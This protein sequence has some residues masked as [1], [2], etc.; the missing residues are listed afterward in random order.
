MARIIKCICHGT[1]FARLRKI[2]ES[3]K[4]FSIEKLQRR[5]TFAENCRRCVPY[6]KLMLETGQTEFDL[7]DEEPDP[8]CEV[9]STTI[10]GDI[11]IF[12]DEDEL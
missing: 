12:G 9:F 7:L 5:A 6:I 1:T 2:S 4:L 3:E 10:T 11:E 8:G